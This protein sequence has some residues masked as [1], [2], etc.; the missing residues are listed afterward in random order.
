MRRK[1]TIALFALIGA[2]LAGASGFLGFQALSNA[3]IQ[4]EY[5]EIE[6]QVPSYQAGEP[7]I[8]ADQTKSFTGKLV[9]RVLDAALYDD[10]DAAASAEG[11]D[12]S[13]IPGQ[14][15]FTEEMKK[16]DPFNVLVFHVEVE[17]INATPLEGS[18]RTGRALFSINDLASPDPYN[19]PLYLSD[20]ESDGDEG[21]FSLPQGEKKTYTRIVSVS[22]H[23]VGDG[24]FTFSGVSTSTKYG[25]VPA[26]KMTLQA[27]D[28]RK[29]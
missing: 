28:K 24:T 3:Q 7:I 11:I 23:S 27:Q 14:Q 19:D 4:K 25:F 17:N 22:E 9:V 20:G 5:E 18:S 26:Y 2:C 6:N 13:S 10:I 16:S 1:E 12:P 21:Y 15:Y 8:F 29:E